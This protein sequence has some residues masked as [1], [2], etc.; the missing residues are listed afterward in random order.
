[1]PTFAMLFDMTSIWLW[2]AV[3]PDTPMN[4]ESKAIRYLI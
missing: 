1:V 4:N 3:K 2:Y